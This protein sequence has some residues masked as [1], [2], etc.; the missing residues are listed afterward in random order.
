M[1]ALNQ[2][3]HETSISKILKEL[4]VLKAVAQQGKTEQD[5]K[6]FVKRHQLVAYS[7]LEKN[8]G[9]NLPKVLSSSEMGEQEKH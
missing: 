1:K 8:Q 9:S 7:D 3:I 4:R 6:Q 5:W 2:V